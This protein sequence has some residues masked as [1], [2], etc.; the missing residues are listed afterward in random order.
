[1]STFYEVEK[2]Y[3]EG[4][5]RYPEGA[6]YNY[7]DGHHQLVIYMADLLDVEI[8]SVKAGNANF[9]FTVI[10]QSIILMYQ[11]A[12]ALPWGDAPFTIH[13]V[14]EKYRKLPPIEELSPESRAFIHVHLIDADTGI[15]KVV[16]SMTLSPSFTRHL[17]DQIRLQSMQRDFDETI[18]R[19]T[20][21]K[22]YDQHCTPALLSLAIDRCR[23]GA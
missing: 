10:S 15:L 11:F 5:D 21:K 3:R 12:P 9:A 2:P 1:M 19:D 20:L 22:L 18:Y 4:I 23:G 14:P 6:E 13:L 7:Y 16:R 17:H 8:G